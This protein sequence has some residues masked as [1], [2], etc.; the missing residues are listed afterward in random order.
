MMFT[1]AVLFL[2]LQVK[3]LGCDDCSRISDSLEG[4]ELLDM[5]LTQIFAFDKTLLQRTAHTFPGLLL[6]AIVR[7][8]IK[9]AI[10]GL[11]GVIH[12]LYDKTS[13][14][15]SAGVSYSLS[16]PPHSLLS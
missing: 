7:C 12:S 16:E 15:K 13:A 2:L 11:D 4:I 3:Y 9:K 1:S 14:L 6:V 10:T 8:T 5:Q